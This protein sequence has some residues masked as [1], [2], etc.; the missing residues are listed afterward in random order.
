MSK[1]IKFRRT[2]AFSIVFTMLIC[3]CPN[4]VFAK[5]S[6]DASDTTINN[7]QLQEEP[8]LDENLLEELEAIQEDTYVNTDT[9]LDI[10]KAQAQT[11]PSIIL[12]NFDKSE[13][14]NNARGIGTISVKTVIWVLKKY[15]TKVIK[16]VKKVNKSWGEKLEKNYSKILNYLD[17]LKGSVEAVLTK[18]LMKIGL[19]E[20]A[21]ELV[22]DIIITIASW[23]I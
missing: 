19:S 4:F 20:S 3:C 15:K 1:L 16:T 9:V 22:A 10:A 6:S 12:E 17:T 11:P 14:R 5:E 13:I 7:S 21:A 8:F 2:I 23:V 18:A